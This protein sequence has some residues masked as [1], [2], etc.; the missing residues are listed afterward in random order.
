MKQHRNAVTIR[1]GERRFDVPSFLCFDVD[2]CPNE[3]RAN[4]S[5]K[6]KVRMLGAIDELRFAK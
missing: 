2:V 4:G 5:I 6:K 1:S 3:W